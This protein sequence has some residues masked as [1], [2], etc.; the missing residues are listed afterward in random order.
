MPGRDSRSIRFRNQAGKEE[1]AS[2]HFTLYAAGERKK[3]ALKALLGYWLLAILSLPIMIAHFVLVPG[4]LL[5][6]IL[7]ASK[8][9]KT[10]QEAESAEGCCPSCGNRICL[11]LDKKNELPQW[12]DCPECSEPLELRA[13]GEAER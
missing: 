10:E 3:R 5:A 4:F 2:M 7:V 8:R 12:H 6:G 11:A 1:P 9:W 13:S